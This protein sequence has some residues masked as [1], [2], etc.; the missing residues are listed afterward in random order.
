MRFSN[1]NQ[2]HYF[3]WC[4]NTIKTSFS[5][6]IVSNPPS[7][8][9][10]VHLFAITVFHNSTVLQYTKMCTKARRETRTHAYPLGTWV[11]TSLHHRAGPI[12]H[13]GGGSKLKPQGHAVS[14]LSQG[15]RGR[16]R[17]CLLDTESP[18]LVSLRT[19]GSWLAFRAWPVKVI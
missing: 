1:L 8:Y 15:S 13:Q 19:G 7:Y 16:G 2:G 11:Q 10:W 17:H 6:Q 5:L 4:R 9:C 14:F 12:F 18:S 3:Q